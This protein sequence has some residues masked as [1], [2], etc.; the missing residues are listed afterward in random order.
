MLESDRALLEAFR[1]GEA[2]ALSRVF[3]AF[4][5]DVLRTI[6]S[7]V[8][9]E[10][11]GQR[12]RVGG[13]LQAH[14][15]EALVQETF[16]RAFAP[17][18]RASYDGLR[19]YGAYLATIAKNLL[20][21][22]AR[23]ERRDSQRFVHVNDIDSIAGPPEQTDPSLRIEE[24]QMRAIVEAV[25]RGLGEPEASIFRLRFEQ[26]LS[27]RE[28]AEA[29][30]GGITP[31][32]IRRREANLHALLLDRLRKAGFLAETPVRIKTRFLRRRN[33]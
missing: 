9:V 13:R 33:G 7:G 17:S 27:V 3:R 8:V 31:V 29:I 2:Q 10:V 18:A 25:K 24:Q 4:A 1:R 19:P 23:A 26:R 28:A 21:D 30:G 14:E 15:I 16:A 32:M 5:D 22:G 20:I 6:R 12:V 11:D